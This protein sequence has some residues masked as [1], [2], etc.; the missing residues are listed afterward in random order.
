LNRNFYSVTA[1]EAKQPRRRKQK[2]EF[3]ALDRH[4]A[5]RLAMMVD[6]QVPHYERPLL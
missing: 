2:P 5:S 4:A 6:M 1:S 3:P